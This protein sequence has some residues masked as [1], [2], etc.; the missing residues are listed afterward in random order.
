[1]FSMLM[2]ICKQS[3]TSSNDH[4]MLTRDDFLF[5]HHWTLKDMGEHDVTCNCFNCVRLLLCHSFLQFV[6]AQHASPSGMGQSS[7]IGSLPCTSLYTI[8][9]LETLRRCIQSTWKNGLLVILCQFD[10]GDDIHATMRQAAMIW[11]S[12]KVIGSPIFLNMLNCTFPDWQDKRCEF[13]ESSIDQNLKT[14][15]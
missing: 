8:N 1:M 9:Y 7:E 11:H 14:A 15:A 12:S 13:T 6:A 4:C 3:C 5:L 10:S 2:D